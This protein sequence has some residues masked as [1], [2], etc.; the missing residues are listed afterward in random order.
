MVGIVSKPDTYKKLQILSADAQYDLACACGT[1]KDGHRTRSKGGWI[2]PVTL[3]NGGT[4][5]LFKTLI[6]NVCTNDCA[7]CPLRRNQDIPRCSLGA[8]ETANSFLDYY[9][10]R[11]VFGLFLSSSVIGSADATMER[12]CAIAQLLRKKH[13]FRG[14]IHLKII[15]GCSP[16]AVEKAVSLSTAVSLNIETPG[17]KY[18]SRL[19]QKKD[20]LRDII[21]PIKLISKLTAKGNK[22]ER[23][24]QTTQFIVAAAGESDAE[25]IK[26]T[27]GLYK[28]LNLSRIY[29]NAY[30]KT[31]G[32]Q[33]LLDKKDDPAELFTREHRL[34]QVDFLMRKYG[35]TDADIICEKDGNLLLDKDP[36][37]T[38]ADNHPEA[39]PVN[40]NRA[41][42]LQL[43]R[44]PGLGPVTVGR[45]L[46]RRH[47]SK[48]HRIE[49]IGKFGIRLA[50]AQKY[51]SF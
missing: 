4:S 31:L 33:R 25:I 47:S 41:S 24:K 37:Q 17:A 6:S 14:Y 13:K 3:P 39:F 2:Y 9:N 42:K 10:R 5:V 36:K 12:L 51:L 49:D 38:W 18:L 22:F 19:S 1:A 26:Y 48:L 43:L 32:E 45:I 29:Y 40:V 7:Y 16:A 21:E 23:V 50:K 8:E 34:Y 20:F 27:W 30:Q 11:E 46:Y 28:R 15:P 44:V 35:F